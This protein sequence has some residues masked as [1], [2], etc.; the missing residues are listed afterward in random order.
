MPQVLVELTRAECMA[1]LS[2]GDFGRV[3]VSTGGSQIPMIRPVTYRFDAASQ[4]IVFRTVEGSKFHTLVHS[5]RAGFEID[6][7]DRDAGSGWSVIVIGTAELITRAAEI[8]RLAR[9]HFST[10]PDGSRLHWVRIR[11]RTVSGRR[12]VPAG[13]PS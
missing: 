12:L 1:L 4:S 13:E 7:H 8:D 2:E 5:G 9:L 11:T 10:W 3:V 6:G